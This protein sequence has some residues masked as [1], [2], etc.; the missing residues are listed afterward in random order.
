MVSAFTSPCL[1]PTIQLQ[2]LFIF[3]NGHSVPKKHSLPTPP[4]DHPCS[5]CPWALDSLGTSYEWNRVC[6][7]F[8]DWLISLGV[9]SPRFV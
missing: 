7:S 8:G 2:D 4:W 3:P 5:L 6:S 9:M 1:I